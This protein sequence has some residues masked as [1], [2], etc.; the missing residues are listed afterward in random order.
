MWEQISFSFGFGVLSSIGICLA[1]CTPVLIAYLI[2]TERDPRKFTGWMILFVALRA[3]VFVA[4]TFLILMLGRLALDFIREFA[5]LLHAAG[6]TLISL[7]GVLIF[8]DIGS[9]LKFFRTKSKGFMILSFLFGIKPCIPHLAI[10]GYL[11]ISVA[12][13]MV[14]GTISLFEA[15]AGAL[16]ISISFSIGENIVP[17]I[18]AALGGKS[19]RY[20][21]GSVFKIVSKV[22]GVL[23]FALGIVFI[24]YDRVAPFLARALS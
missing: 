23:L 17:L 12:A 4:M 24:F 1:S 15:V 7:A 2:S 18:L 3:I 11:L 14:E 21:R 8:F 13:P 6:G 5:F 16:A 19:I 20:F 10:W 9:K 22:C